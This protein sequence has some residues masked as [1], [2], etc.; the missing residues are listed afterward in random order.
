VVRIERGGI[1]AN[2]TSARVRWLL[3]VQS[4]MR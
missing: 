4:W 1:V 2:E 3:A